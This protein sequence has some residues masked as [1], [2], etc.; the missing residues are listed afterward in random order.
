MKK[1][2][3]IT[4]VALV[5]TIIILLILVGVTINFIIGENG[6]IGIAKHAAQEYKN[7]ESNEIGDLDKL[8][9]SI[10]I[11]NGSTI[12]LTQEQLDEYIKT[13]ANPTGVKT[14]TF[15]RNQRTA[16]SAYNTVTSMNGF[17]RTMDENNKIA[18]YLSYSDT[19]GYTVQKSG[20]YYIRV[21][22]FVSK[23]SS[24]ETCNLMIYCYLNSVEMLRAK[25]HTGPSW[26]SDNDSAPIY[27]KQGD[28]VHFEAFGAGAAG[29]RDADCYIYPMF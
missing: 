7:A 1:N 27:L 9:S 15:V 25:A 4:L 8:Y 3:G 29:S 22:A 14:D 24:G 26:G 12:T 6:I 13:K 10:K 19:D 18:E 2:K 21:M 20:W 5:I 28:K 16:T 11:A 23:K 17:T